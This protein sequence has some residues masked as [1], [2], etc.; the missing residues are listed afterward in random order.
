M[1]DLIEK[2]RLAQLT[3]AELAVIDDLKEK[4][5][6]HNEADRSTL[7]D[8]LEPLEVDNRGSTTADDDIPF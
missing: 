4:G 5:L 7:Y 6:L 1:T 8:D 3:A 2:I